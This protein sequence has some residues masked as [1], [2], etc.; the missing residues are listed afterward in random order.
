MSVFKTI[1]SKVGPRIWL[2][3]TAV[4]LVLVITVTVLASTFFFEL[5]CIPLG[6]VRTVGRGDGRYFNVTA[7]GKKDAYD[8]GNR[9]NETICEEGFVLLKNRKT[10]GRPALPLTSQ[11]N[12]ISV[13][14]K[15]SAGIVYGG[16]GSGG[17]KFDTAQSLYDSLEEAGF[18]LNPKLT[19]FYTGS[20]SGEGRTPNPKIEN[21]GRIVLETGETPQAS[22]TGEIVGSYADYNDAAVIV[23]SRIGG[24]GF[25]L[26]R[27]MTGENGARHYL[28]LDKNES[29]LLEAVTGAAFK[30]IIVVLNCS[31]SFE[32]AG[33][34]GNDRIDACISAGGPGYAGIS[35]LGG[36]LNGS[37]TPSGKTV[38][39]WAAD[40]TDDPT[41]QNFADNNKTDGASY[42]NG[43]KKSGY[44]FVDYE[45]S[46]YVGYRY[47]ETRGEDEGAAW[48]QENV[49]YP[50][51]F[52]LSYTDFEWE[53]DNA[54]ELQNLVIDDSNK[55][56]TFEIRVKVTNT[57]DRPGKDVVQLY[58]SAPRG[59]VEKPSAVLCGFE[60]T[61]VLYPSGEANGTDKPDSCV[62]K[63]E[64]DPYYAASYDSRGSGGYILEAG[65]YALTIR[66]DAHSVKEDTAPVTYTVGGQGVSF[67]AGKAV[68]RFTDAA[69]GLDTVLSR[70]A[71]NGSF[72]SSPDTRE[73]TAV[74]KEKLASMQHNNPEKDWQM[75]VTKKRTAKKVVE[76]RGLPLDDPGWNELLDS[77][78]FEEM[79]GLFNKGAFKTE[80]INRIGLPATVASDGP[81]GF[82]NFMSGSNIYDTVYYAS[83]YVMGCTW[84]KDLIGR[85]GEAVG[86]EAAYGNERAK[87]YVPYSG[88][89]AP[90]INLH[91]SPFGGRNFEYFSEDP[92]L[93]GMLAAAEIKG[94]KSRGLVTYMKHFALND[95]ESFRDKNGLCTWATEQAIREL[96]LRPF[97]IAVKDGGANGIMTSFNRI[98]T[99]WTGGDYRLLTEVLRGEWGFKGTVICDF[100]VSN[101]MNPKQMIYAGGDL[102]LTTTK[103]WTNP[104]PESAGDLSMLRRAARNIMFTVANSNAMNGI[105]KETVLATRMPVWQSVLIII[106]CVIVA[107]L[108]FWGFYILRKTIREISKR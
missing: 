16:T 21:D 67:D 23:I 3:V 36:I 79:K 81:V 93:S 49:V 30:K 94:A 76:M 5:I 17:G 27:M 40:F 102:N 89:Y 82:V 9:L 2:I 87:P 66:A 72:P 56:E 101:Y 69:D 6:D 31:T 59:D 25:D 12:R 34:Q 75:P 71:W 26:P 35:A 43:G 13:F 18:T 37:V 98:G 77:L 24:E 7:S 108:G 29:D 64:F 11:E 4:T 22:Y 61:P 65:Q 28:E 15:N 32:A 46:I 45:E 88:W 90:G 57:G 62:L 99:K 53:I 68:N 103:P 95:Q 104:S 1:F 58:C 44:Y 41:W 47:Y 38:D 96:Y 70:N 8:R 20:A 100:N 14:G 84:N 97:E 19:E 51:G 85:M 78:S 107:A 83:Q 91:R 48:Y 63:I 80:N 86:D 50:F 54:E 55:N 60:K 74:L 33:I 39:T 73:M 10:A 52:G 105:N 92:F 106:D 42:M